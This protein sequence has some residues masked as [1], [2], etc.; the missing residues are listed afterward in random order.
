MHFFAPG[1]TEIIGNHTDHQLGRVIASAVRLGISADIDIT[2]DTDKIILYSEGFGVISVDTNDIKPHTMEIGT[3]A[4][5][6]RGMVCAISE[7]GYR[8]G[9][10]RG[11]ITSSLPAGGGLSSSA[12]FTILVGRIINKLYN[13]GRIPAQEL[14]RFAQRAENIHFGKP[15]GLMDQLACSLEQTVYIDFLYNEVR[16]IQCEFS[17]MGLALCLTNTGGSHSGL[18][19]AYAEIAEDMHKVAI[20][21]GEE[22]LGQIPYDSFL[23][24]SFP[25]DRIH[26]R[27]R[28]F[29]EEN[30]RV[31]LM[32]DAIVKGNRE[33]CLLLMNASGR[34]SEK[35]LQN[36]KTPL[37]D[38]LLEQGLLVS[39]K[40]L[41]GKG[42]WRVHGGG[43]A[44]CVQALVPLA[45]VDAYCSGMDMI[46]GKNSCLKIM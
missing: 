23:K 38:N 6:V 16:P 46:F 37:G 32:M 21:L 30:A 15:S 5:L 27:A 36:I 31:P 40:L 9:G 18:T 8:V 2:N 3:T 4:A 22:K 29:F 26:N 41:E 25:N 39:E 28:H 11:K 44:G 17:K 19:D 34:S 43:F 10:F 20:E 42:A 14:A 13:Q 7:A 45:D 1:R 33:N 35:L 12:A 24:L